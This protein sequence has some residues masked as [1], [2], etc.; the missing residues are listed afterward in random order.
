MSMQ[1]QTASLGRGGFRCVARRVAAGSAACATLA[2]LML[3]LGALA[4]IL[5]PS[6]ALP[7]TSF[8]DLVLAH[9]FTR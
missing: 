6:G 8:K 2:A 9:I 1:P 7:A 5:L 4:Q 3:P